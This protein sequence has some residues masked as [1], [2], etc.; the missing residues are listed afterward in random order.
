MS[1]EEL[2]LRCQR[3]V[4][5]NS[6]VYSVEQLSPGATTTE[7]EFWSPRAVTTEAHILWGP[8][9]TVNEPLCAPTEAPVPRAVLSKRSHCKEKPTHCN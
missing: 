6:C 8:Q 4:I 3:K 7:P 2:R 5:Q 9:A 1:R